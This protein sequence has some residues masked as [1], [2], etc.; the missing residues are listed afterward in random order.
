MMP[1]WGDEE[2]SPSLR[3]LRPTMTIVNCEVKLDIREFISYEKARGDCYRLLSA[4]FYTPKKELFIQ[5]GLLKNLTGLLKQTCPGAAVFSVKMEKAAQRYSNEDLLVEYAKLF[6]GPYELIAPPYGSVY[7]DNERRVMGDSTMEVIKMYQESGLSM[8]KD[9]KELPDHIAAEL[10][11]MYY[12]I[13]KETEALEESEID[14]ALSYLKTQ[15]L[16]LN[17]FLGRWISPFCEKMKEGTDNEFYAAL[18]SCASS[19]VMN[20]Q[21]PDDITESIKEK[22]MRV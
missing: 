17:R 20:S 6:V 22:G 12:L 9:F 1:L 18:A 21:L 10:E 8:D 13:Y 5:D 4:C 7:L 14:A 2:I 11:F 16:F 3:L 15:E 19:F